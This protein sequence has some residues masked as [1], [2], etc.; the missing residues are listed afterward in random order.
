M[1]IIKVK[2]MGKL[3]LYDTACLSLAYNKKPRVKHVSDM[4]AARRRTDAL[5]MLLS[6]AIVAA[7]AA[8]FALSL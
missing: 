7:L 1:N 3:S 6:I 2:H 8:A 4:I 5:F